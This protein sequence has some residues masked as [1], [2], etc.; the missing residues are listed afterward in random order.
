MLCGFKEK[1]NHYSQLKAFSP[2]KRHWNEL[3]KVISMH[4]LITNPLGEMM[5]KGP[6]THNILSMKFKFTI[7]TFIELRNRT[8]NLCKNIWRKIKYLYKTKLENYRSLERKYCKVLLPK[9]VQIISLLV[10]ATI[11]DFFHNSSG[12]MNV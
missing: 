3:I 10:H 9:L 1:N 4:W 7:C 8:L 12:K 5:N 11:D 6:E 2:L